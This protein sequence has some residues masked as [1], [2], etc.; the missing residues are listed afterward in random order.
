MKKFML[1]Y[2]LIIGAISS[3]NEPPNKWQDADA[4][5]LSNKIYEGIDKMDTENG[6]VFHSHESKAYGAY[7][8]WKQKNTGACFIVIRGTGSLSDIFD[9]LLVKEI[10]DEEIDVKVHLGVKIR[11]DY[12]IKNIDDRL[13]VCTEDIIIT[14]HSLGGAIAYYLYLLY[15]KRHLEDWG[16]KNKASRFKAVLFG[17][18]SLIT[19]SGKDY[20]ANFD[21]YVNW[22]KYG[23]DC[24]PFIIG[25]VKGSILFQILS[26]LFTS[27]GITIVEDAYN[28][29]QGVNYGYHHP[30][31]KYHLKHGE[32]KEYTFDICHFDSDSIFDHM[33][34][35]K[36]VDILTKIWFETGS[37]YSKNNNTKM[38]YINFLNEE[39]ETKEKENLSNNETI[40]ID[41]ANCEDVSDFVEM[42]NFTNAVLYTKNEEND[43]YYII[44]RLLDNE[45]EY[46]YAIC[47]NNKFILKQ[48]NGKCE[49]HEVTKNDRPKEITHCNSY[50]SE[51][52]MNCLV[53]G[54]YKEIGI[55]EYFSVINQI[56]IEDYYLMDYFCLNQT[57][58][59]GN[60]KINDDNNSKYIIKSSKLL[61]LLILLNLLI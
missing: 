18:P 40:D 41:T 48:C 20:I 49:C 30:G 3:P 50:Q 58:S 57:Y 8:V 32:K 31:H 28:T 14:G 7:A 60:Y 5:W 61:L 42:V 10:Y 23:G 38:D 24:V 17:T 29:V 26:K 9:D 43:F 47:N 53:D 6:Y 59:R 2:L 39:K 45:K 44:K 16:E 55:T 13:K 51:N 1:F 27:L 52:V 36:Y 37:F 35:N 33:L 15:V 4:V 19:R 11:T 25:K 21:N 56:K 46:E 54:N 22:Y 12:Y 34:L